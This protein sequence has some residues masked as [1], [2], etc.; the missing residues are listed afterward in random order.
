MLSHSRL[1]GGIISESWESKLDF[2]LILGDGV[3]GRTD[4]GAVDSLAVDV[5]VS[6]ARSAVDAA[7]ECDIELGLMPGGYGRGPRRMTFS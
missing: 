6:L 2:F 5:R 7:G 3:V 4:D 1:G